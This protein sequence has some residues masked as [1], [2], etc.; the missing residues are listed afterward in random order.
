V[1]EIARFFKMPPSKLGDLADATFSNV[2]QETLSYFTSCL[3]PWLR[4][5]E[6]ELNAKL[7]S[8]LER[9]QQHIEHV[10]EGLLRA[11]AEKR[12]LFYAQMLA[13]GVLTV[14]EVRALENLSPID[15][16]DVA[17]VPMNTSS[18]TENV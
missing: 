12:G 7:V 14:N 9:E 13:H 4:R 8:R 15:G 3:R 5:I 17:R 6:E 11:D 1:R 16:G 18:L 10:V 2:E